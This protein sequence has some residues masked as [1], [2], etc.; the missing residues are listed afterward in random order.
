ME[1][2]STGSIRV[3]VAEDHHLVRQGVVE[4]LGAAGGIEVVGQAADGEE[5]IEQFADLQPDVTIVDLRMP[6]KGGVEVIRH[7]RAKSPQARFIVLTT[8]DGDEDIHRALS[9]GA[10]AYLLKV[11]T[12]SVL[13]EAI[14]A[15]HAGAMYIPQEIAQKLGERI[16][17]RELTTRE[18]NVLEEIVRGKSN[19]EI[20]MRLKISIATVKTHVNG[21]LE[22]LGAA[23]RAE[24]AVVAIRRGIVPFESLK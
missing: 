1:I 19:L 18:L 23:S 13:V 12:I 6:R 21:V 3:L 15:V 24:A 16:G 2:R 11:L 17:S 20:A 22:K 4:L 5:A 8:N 14:R 10:R 9:A 7:V